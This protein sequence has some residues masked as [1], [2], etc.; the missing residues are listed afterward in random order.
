MLEVLLVIFLCKKNRANALERGK[1]PGGFIALTILLW[2]I[3]EVIG[4]LVGILNEWSQF[5]SM[6]LGLVFAGIGAVIAWAIAKFGP[7][8]DYVDPNTQVV[9]PQFGNTTPGM[10]GASRINNINIGTVCPKCGQA[11]VAGSEYCE[12]CGAKFGN[13]EPC[14]I[15]GFPNEKGSKFCGSCGSK[16]ETQKICPSCG[17]ANMA[18]GRRFCEFCGAKLD[19]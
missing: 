1:R 2:I 16:F 17:E 6:F 12:F 13:A 9:S 10:A 5:G 14:P 15:C 7:Q 3:P 18:G 8:G 19:N 4:C 11:N